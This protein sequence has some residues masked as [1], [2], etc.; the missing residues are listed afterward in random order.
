MIQ[1]FIGSVKESQVMIISLIKLK[2]WSEDI[3]GCFDSLERQTTDWTS[4]EKAEELVNWLE[5]KALVMLK[6]AESTEK[7][8]YS[9]IKK[10]LI[11]K[12]TPANRDFSLK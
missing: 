12:L 9:A 4:S 7:K 1:E 2:K 8:N 3:V 10:H 5:E 6:K 11:N